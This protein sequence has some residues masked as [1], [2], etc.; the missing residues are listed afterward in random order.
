VSAPLYLVDREALDGVAVGSTVELSGPE[1]RH[2][3]Q[4]RRV[5]AGERVDLADGGG[6]RIEGVVRRV[7]SD[8]GESG[9]AVE[10]EVV[11]W[12]I[13]PAADPRFVLVQALAKGDRDL[14]AVE[15][16]TELG[17]DEIVPWQA[18]RSIVVWRDDRAVKAHRRWAATAFA[19]TKQARRARL[20]EVGAL[21]T[22]D[23]L[24]ARVGQAALALVLHEGAKGVLAAVELPPTGDVVL[25]VGPEGGISPG[26]LERLEE[27]GALAVRLGPAVLRSSSA[28]PAA[29]AVLSARTRWT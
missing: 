29:L 20:P 2:A 5:R 14:S 7:R 11:A 27:A 6:T 22:T 17:V 24:A 19:A 23:E 21:V 4:V 1:G 28:G 13:E 8:R 16:A 26:E 9:P 18:E 10:L 12:V 3:V 25:V 15:T